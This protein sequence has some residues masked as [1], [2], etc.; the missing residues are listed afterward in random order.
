MCWAVIDCGGSIDVR[1]LPYARDF[2]S[3]EHRGQGHC[4]IGGFTTQV[5]SRTRGVH[6][7]LHFADGRPG[8]VLDRLDGAFE[9]LLPG[10]ERAGRPALSYSEQVVDA[11]F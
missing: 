4:G 1:Y 11:F 3:E 6:G 5:V 8:W 10:F 7:I 2:R 9:Q